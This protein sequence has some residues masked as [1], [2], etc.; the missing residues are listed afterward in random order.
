VETVR[1]GTTQ[2][3]VRNAT[4]RCTQPFNIS[5]HPAITLPCGTTASGLPIGLQVVGSRGNTRGLLRIARE[6]ERVLASPAS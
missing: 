3:S 2:E 4:L 1:V 5:G 6:I